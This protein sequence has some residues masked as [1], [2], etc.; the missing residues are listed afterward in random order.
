MGARDVLGQAAGLI[1]LIFGLSMLG[2]IRLPVFSSERRIGV[3]KILVLGRWESSLLIGALFAV[4]WS[5]CIGP[6]LGTV[7]L[8][9]STSN[10]ALA[11][12]FLLGVFSFGLAIPF[13]LTALLIHQAT[14][15]FNRWSRFIKFFTFM[16]GITLVGLGLLMLSGNMGLLITWGYVLFEFGNYDR[17]LEY[18]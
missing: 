16:G 12:A 10:G 2:V 5:P 9:A 3:P 6:I 11:G 4:G 18:L 14:A 15:A 17:L 13:L 1:I 8:L 7:L